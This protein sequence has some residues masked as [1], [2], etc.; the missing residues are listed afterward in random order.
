MKVCRQ[1]SVYVVFVLFWFFS[2][3]ARDFTTLITVFQ[4]R[5]FQ[6]HVLKCVCKTINYFSYFSCPYYWNAS[7]SF[8]TSVIN[9]TLLRDHVYR[10]MFE[11]TLG[12]WVIHT[13]YKQSGT[14]SEENWN[15]EWWSF[16]T[17]KK[18]LFYF[19]TALIMMRSL[20]IIF[21]QNN[22][23][24]I[25]QLDYEAI[26]TYIKSTEAAPSLS[27]LISYVAG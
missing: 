1:P 27:L 24:N 19:L 20:L 14:I 4:L 6:L 5:D 7:I 18:H 11:R 3:R 13:V 8:S 2:L 12:V 23:D 16:E 9:I 26:F 21:S 15:G 17:K 10:G 25:I 22:Y